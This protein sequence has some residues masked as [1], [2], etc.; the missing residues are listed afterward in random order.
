MPV[1]LHVTHVTRHSALF[2]QLH[3]DVVGFVLALLIFL[4]C[5]LIIM[6]IFSVQLCLTFMV[7]L[8]NI[9]WSLLD[10]GKCLSINLRNVFPMLLFMFL[11]NSELNKMM[12]LFLFHF[13]SLLGVNSRSA[14]CPESFSASSYSVV[15]L[16][17]IS[18]PAELSDSLQLIDAG[19]C[20]MVVRG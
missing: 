20:L 3:E 19:I 1:T 6:D 4:L 12:F 15:A 2:R 9:L 11:L 18:S 7:F 17:K 13:V 16:L 14:M 8:L 5:F 10:Q